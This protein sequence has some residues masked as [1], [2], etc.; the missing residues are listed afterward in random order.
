MAKFR[1]NTSSTIKK[2]DL[3]GK[4]NFAD[5][6]YFILALPFKIIGGLI[7]SCFSSFRSRY[8]EKHPEAQQRMN[9]KC[10]LRRRKLNVVKHKLK[11]IDKKITR[12]AVRSVNIIDRKTDAFVERSDIKLVMLGHHFHMAKEWAEMNKKLLLCQFAGL[13]GIMLCFIGIFNVCT[14]YEYAYNGRTLGIVNNQ[15]DVLRI[16]DLVSENLT[17]EHNAEITIDKSEDIEFKRVFSVG[18][19]VDNMEQVLN[20]LTYMQ[21]LVAQGCGIFID[22]KRVAIVDN[23]ETANA[24]LDTVLATFAVPSETT[25]YEEIGFAE[26]VKVAQVETRLGRI[27]NPDDVIQKI[28]TGAEEIKTHI[29][30]SGDTFSGIA[31]TYNIST[32]DLQAANPLVRPER[33][34][35][36][37]E[38]ILTQAVPMLTVQTVEVS[39]L[40]EYLQFQTVYEDNPSV[41]QGE[42]STKVA[43]KMGER[44]VVAKIVKNNGVEVARMELESQITKEPVTAV[45][46]VGTKALPPKQGM[47]TFIYPV[48]GA[49]LTSRF[50]TRWGRMHYG[51]DLAI[52]TGTKIR[53]SDGGTVI[54]SGYSGSYGYVV[55]IDHGGGYVTVYAHCSKLHV[56][57]GDKVYQGQHIANVGST[58]RSTGPHCHFEVQ[59]LGVQK[60]PLNYL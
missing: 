27:E 8:F 7:L 30:Q 38:I 46:S 5:G 17:E 45:I 31:K 25:T 60:N 10:G 13:I 55:K 57:V 37:Q 21:D 20:K 28:L 15:E 36:G 1:K 41:Y 18:K 40:T 35:I 9:E 4:E 22:D 33:L 56:K 3:I 49:K 6:I 58:G 14:A 47:G 34:V 44:Q 11:K 24:V 2:E 43:G 51:I 53:A 59:Y 16:L 26:D 48:T 52:A 42:T 29:V 12:F 32:A 19:D 50:G 54:F 39:S 23:E